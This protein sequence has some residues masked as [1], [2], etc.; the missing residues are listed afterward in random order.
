MSDKELSS[1]APPPYPCIHPQLTAPPSATEDLSLPKG[2]SPPPIPPPPARP[3]RRPP[4]TVQKIITEVLATT[5]PAATPALSFPRETRDLLISASVE[6]VTMLTSEANELAERAGKKT[7]ACEHVLG[8]ARDL[9]FPEYVP[10]LQEAAAA[11]RAGQASAR[12]KKGG[13]KMER[14]GL[15]REELIRAQE[16]LFRDAGEKF[17]EGGAGAAA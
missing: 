17:G 14:S 15:S 10:A 7:V 13:G 5:Y 12:E 8:A 3:L 2:A 9:G 6:F 4:A 11:W 16:E 1:C